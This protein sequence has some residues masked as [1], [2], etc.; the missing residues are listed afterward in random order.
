[1]THLAKQMFPGK[2]KAFEEIFQDATTPAYG[3][4]FIDL[5][6]QTSESLRLRTGIF[7]GDKN[8]VYEP[9]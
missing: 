2:T 7:H 9:R 4:L 1:M 6:P 5:R 3:Y 8:Y